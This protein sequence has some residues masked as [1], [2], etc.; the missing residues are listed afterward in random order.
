MGRDRLSNV[1]SSDNRCLSGGWSRSLPLKTETETRQLKVHAQSF[2]LNRGL[3]TSDRRVFLKTDGDRWLNIL[4]RGASLCSA[5]SRQ[6][7]CEFMETS[8]KINQ[9][10]DRAITSIVRGLRRARDAVA[11]NREGPGK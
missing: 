6:L 1:W 3:R 9:N 7:G 8:A 10:V 2:A 5:R 11:A 4:G